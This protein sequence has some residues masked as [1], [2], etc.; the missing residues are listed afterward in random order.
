MIPEIQ[1]YRNLSER[2]NKKKL[3]RERER[4]DIEG[5]RWS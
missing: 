2:G 1:K 4:I 3:E 5:P